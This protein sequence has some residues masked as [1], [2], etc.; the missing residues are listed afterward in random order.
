MNK[1][2]AAVLYE[3]E[4]RWADVISTHYEGCW[5]VHAA[6]LATLLTDLENE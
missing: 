3:V 2:Q 4:V 6:C 1:R 5:Q